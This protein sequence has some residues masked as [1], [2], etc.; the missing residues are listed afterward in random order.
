LAK[1]VKKPLIETNELMALGYAWVAR[2]NIE[3]GKLE[4]VDEAARLIELALN[5]NDNLQ[6]WIRFRILMA[7]G[8]IFLK[9][10]KSR[11]ALENFTRA[12]EQMTLYGG[13][14]HYYQINPRI[15]LANLALGDLSKAEMIFTDLSQQKKISIGKLYGEYGLALIKF[16]KGDVKEANLLFEQ[17][18]GE[19]SK[20]TSSNLLLKLIKEFEKTLK[21]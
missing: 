1:E 11:E 13:E 16:K 12:R 5:F 20:R 2:V 18:K 9:Q 8:D 14:G 19:L 4:L 10:N 6:P 3:Q 7:A 21:E 15:G 17:V